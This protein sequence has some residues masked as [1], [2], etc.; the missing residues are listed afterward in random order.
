MDVIQALRDS[1]DPGEEEAYPDSRRVPVSDDEI[2]AFE[3]SHRVALPGLAKDFYRRVNGMTHAE[4]ER[5]VNHPL[6]KFLSLGK[7]FPVPALDAGEDE[8]RFF[9]I[10]AAGHYP[11]DH[12][13][14]FFVIALG[15]AGTAQNPVHGF[16]GDHRRYHVADSFEEFLVVATR[17]TLF[18]ARLDPE[19]AREMEAVRERAAQ[20]RPWWRFW[21]RA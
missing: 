4:W 11:P 17:Y 19:R 8:A 13:V 16:Y 15:P 9:A 2:A 20:R 12:S 6:V 18:D 10:A 1:W 7:V 3:A 5:D 21:R 14:P